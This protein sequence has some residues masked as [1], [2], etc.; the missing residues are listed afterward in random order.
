[1]SELI[2]IGYNDP[3]VAEDAYATV[4]DLQKDYVVNLNG[5]AIVSVDADGKQHVDTPSKI[6]GVS[7]AS[8][9]LWGTVFGLLFLVPGLGLLA[10]AA[11][12]G[13]LGKLGKSGIDDQFRNQVQELLKPGSSAVVIMASKITEDKFAD[14]MQPYGGTLLKTSL[15]DEDEKELAEHL[16]GAQS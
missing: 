13:L 2:V 7:A 15:N 8:G 5:L 1:M 6:V 9:A 12:G 4:Q 16:A 3:K 10:G 14:A 11:M